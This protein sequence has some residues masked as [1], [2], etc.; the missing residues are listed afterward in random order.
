MQ[1]IQTHYHSFILMHLII[2]L[3]MY[4]NYI[5]F[6]CPD[7]FLEVIFHLLHAMLTGSYFYLMSKGRV[8][9]IHVFM[10]AFVSALFNSGPEAFLVPSSPS[11]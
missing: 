3:Y 8:S 1:L 11:G 10:K 5:T 9:Q 6:K 2:V 7:I 4:S